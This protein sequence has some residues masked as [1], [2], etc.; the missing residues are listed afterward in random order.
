MAKSHS[1]RHQFSEDLQQPGPPPKEQARKVLVSQK[2]PIGVSSSDAEAV[3]L[4]CSS[5]RLVI[6]HHKLRP[7]STEQLRDDRRYHQTG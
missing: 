4:E 1:T 7:P 6:C 5:T 2:L 3:R